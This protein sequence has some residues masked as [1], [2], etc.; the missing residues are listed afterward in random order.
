MTA[1]QLVVILSPI[2]ARN[3]SLR[4]LLGDAS[5]APLVDTRDETLRRFHAVQAS[6][7]TLDALARRLRA[8]PFVEGAYVKPAD[9]LPVRPMPA[10]RTRDTNATTPDFTSR[11]GYLAPAPEGIDA[12]AAWAL[13][14]G[15]GAGVH[16]ID[17]EGGWDFA[18]EDLRI[19]KG[20][21]LVGRP[22]GERFWR[23][24]GT[25]VLGVL[26]GDANAFGVTGIAPDARVSAASHRDRGTAAALYEAAMLLAP[27]DI[28]LVEAHR[29]GPRF[30]YAPRPDQRGYIPVE[31][32]PDDL[33]VIQHVTARGILVVEAAGNGAEDLDDPLYDVPGEGF[34]RTWVNPFRRVNDTGSIVVGAGAPPPGTHGRDRHGPDRSRL[35]FSNHGSMVDAQGWGR[36]VTTTGYGDLQHGDEHRAYTD[37]FSGTSSASPMVAGALACVQGVLRATARPVLTPAQARA[38]LRTY[39]SPQ[40]DRAD[41]PASRTPIG[42]R[43]DLRKM[44]SALEAPRFSVSPAETRVWLAT[45]CALGPVTLYAI[46]AGPTASGRVEIDVFDTRGSHRGRFVTAIAARSDMK[47]AWALAAREVGAPDLHVYT[48]GPGDEHAWVHVLCADDGYTCVREVLRVPTMEAR[49]VAREP[50]HGDE[51][52]VFWERVGEQI[53]LR[54]V[55]VGALGLTVVTRAASVRVAP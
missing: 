15:R 33:A 41:A 26:A 19:N 7:A 30:D 43:P 53:E 36:E 22:F 35:D 54:A 29:P 3:E 12:A 46:T 20:G 4:R 14:G 47:R 38:L 34:P 23:D 50:L 44:L 52:L 11:Q 49:G 5:M 16:V 2:H 45:D 32:W 24:H 42:A 48:Y 55:R 25:A 40:T 31:W 37:T 51:R 10:P 17:V 6:D 1:R 21:V 28:L 8:L 39:G 27:G 9:E 18:H 13:P